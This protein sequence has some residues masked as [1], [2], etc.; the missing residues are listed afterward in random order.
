M[1]FDLTTL[2][3]TIPGLALLRIAKGRSALAK[4]AATQKKWDQI[5]API[6]ETEVPSPP[7]RR[8]RATVTATR[9]MKP[10]SN[11]NDND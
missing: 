10:Y 9:T 6:E 11:G 5:T 1:S 7:P 4:I 3:P 8:Q 2:N